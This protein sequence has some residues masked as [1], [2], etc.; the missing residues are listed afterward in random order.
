MWNINVVR[1]FVGFT[2]VERFQCSYVGAIAFDEI[3]QLVEQSTASCGILN[4]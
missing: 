1:V 3:S 4:A 2:V